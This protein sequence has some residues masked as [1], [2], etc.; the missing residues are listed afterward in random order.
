MDFALLRARQHVH[1]LEEEA[2]VAVGR[3]AEE[4]QKEEAARADRDASRA[5]ARQQLLDAS[6]AVD[7]LARQATF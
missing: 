6:V 4:L 3:V 2:A 7:Q 1:D 5:L